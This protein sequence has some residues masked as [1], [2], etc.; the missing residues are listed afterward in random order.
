MKAFLHKEWNLA[1]P[2][3][4]LLFPLLGIMTVIPNYPVFVGFFY[5]VVAIF[6]L[7]SVQ[8]ENRDLEFS[9][10]LPVSRRSIVKAKF[11]VVGTL[12]WLT[13]AFAVIGAVL[14]DTLVSPAGNLVG[15][16]PNLAFF[17]IAFLALGVF[18]AVFLP[19]FFRTGYKLGL[20]L[21]MAAAC[22]VLC[23]GAFETVVNLVPALRASLDTLDPARF[24]VQAV[25]LAVGLA[26][27]VVSFL[28]SYRAAARRFEAA[29]L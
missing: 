16:D 13:I 1:V 8:K 7:F 14:A 19:W 12:Q 22:F 29:N 24:G 6:V 18:N 3:P 15:I 9:L 27:Y 2:K 23:Y 25:V 4:V 17:G 10:L 11:F 5:G 26:F 28:L 21:T 20:P